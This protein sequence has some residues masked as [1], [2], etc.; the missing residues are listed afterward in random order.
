MNK[1]VGI[2]T[3]YNNNNNYG[4]IAQGYALQ[5]YISARGYDCKLI[6][7]RRSSKGAF[8]ILP[9]RLKG[10]KRIHNAIVRRCEMVGEKLLVK[11]IDTRKR[12]FAISR[13]EIP[14]TE[15]YTEETI[16]SCNSEFDVLVSGSDQIWKPFVMQLPYVL[17]FAAP[18]KTKISYASSISETHLPDTYGLF[19][20]KY[21]SD[22]KAISVRERDAKEYLCAQTG[23]EIEWVVDPVLLLSAEEWK[24]KCLNS[25]IVNEPYIFCYLL[26]DRKEERVWAEKVAKENN[27]KLVVFPH[28]EGRFRFHDLGFGD[29]SI[30]EAGLSEFLTLILYAECIITDSFHATVFSYLLHRQFY[31]LPRRNKNNKENMSSRLTSVLSQM[32]LEDRLIDISK[33]KKTL[34]QNN[35]I[36]YTQTNSKIEAQ[37]RMSKEF[38]KKALEE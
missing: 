25:R 31:V 9:V 18:G 33:R 1:R 28:V 19:M 22:Y 27:M 10:I 32:G 5:K 34:I 23:R 4:G 8:V 12:Y 14:H 36:D 6:N 38:L 3:M 26:G 7:Y 24:S 21:L 35:L 37:I 11:K 15:L 16:K 2:I 13:E 29:I 30:Y 17:S 20:K